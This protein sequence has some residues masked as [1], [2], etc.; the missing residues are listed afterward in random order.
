M[1]VHIKEMSQLVFSVGDK[2]LESEQ[3]PARM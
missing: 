2:G 1:H 3:P